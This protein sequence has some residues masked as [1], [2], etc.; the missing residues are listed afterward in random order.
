MNSWIIVLESLTATDKQLLLSVSNKCQLNR[1][2]RK[3]NSTISQTN[4]A[5]SKIMK[6][7]KNFR[8]S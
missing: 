8:L 4:F 3:K 6:Q 5:I 1:A 7:F 2:C